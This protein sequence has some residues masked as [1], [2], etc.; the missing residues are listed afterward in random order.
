MRSPQ[1]TLQRLVDAVVQ[2]LHQQGFK[3]VKRYVDNIIII[4]LTWADH[5]NTLKALLKELK[6]HNFTL[7]PDK[8]EFGL[9]H[10]HVSPSKENTEKVAYFP[11]PSTRKK[12]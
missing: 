11:A 1:A 9:S 8:C 12:L 7:R 10:N 5:M 4:S 3:G 2:R 6:Q